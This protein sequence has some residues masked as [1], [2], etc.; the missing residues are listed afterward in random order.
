HALRAAREELIAH[1]TARKQ[2]TTISLGGDLGFAAALPLLARTSQLGAI[3]LERPA[4]F[5]RSDLELLSIFSTKLALALENDALTEQ[6][7]RQNS[8]LEA[9]VARRTED[10]RRLSEQRRDLLGM[11]AHDVRGALTFVKLLADPQA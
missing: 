2:A 8:E 3:F 4:A 10:V 5:P 9:E 7:R 11:V 6:L 1:A